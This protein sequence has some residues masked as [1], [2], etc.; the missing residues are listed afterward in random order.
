MKVIRCDVNHLN[1]YQQVARQSFI[2]AFEKVSEP[3]SFKNYISTAF[4]LDILRG[5]LE[6]TKTAIYFLQTDNGESTG[7][8]KLRWDRS[9]EFF[10]A[11]PAL[12]LQRIY[13]LERFWNKGYGKILLDFSENF[14]IENAFQWI[15]LVVW[16]EN[17]GA[18]RFY[19]RQGWEKFATKNFQ[20]GDE[21]HVDPVFKKKL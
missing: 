8:I 1:E 19:E 4:E 2:D 5:E 11:E 16:F 13:L 7:Y 3:K 20:F 14:A 12:E 6:D 21:I 10:G 9:E 15:W 18:I 17:H